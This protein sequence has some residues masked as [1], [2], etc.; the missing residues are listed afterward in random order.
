MNV[1]MKLNGMGGSGDKQIRV[2]LLESRTL[3]RQ[4]ILS[5]CQRR[6]DLIVAL[7]ADTGNQFLNYIR[8]EPVDLVIAQYDHPSVAVPTLQASLRRQGNPVRLMTLLEPSQG[9]WIHA[10]ISA[11]VAG[12]LSTSVSEDQFLD[13]ILR[14]LNGDRHVSVDLDQALHRFLASRVQYSGD[15]VGQVRVSRP[16]LTKKELEVLKVVAEGATID[17]TGY[18]L[19]MSAATVKN[20]RHRIY[21]KLGVDNAPAAIYSAFC[22]GLLK[23]G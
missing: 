5:V 8:N 20:H 9:A 6:D 15:T 18:Q 19:N 14:V 2:A 22:S 21:S 11:G 12:L 23:A 13:A 10:A 4:A 7:T 17:E 16:L 3:I 1:T